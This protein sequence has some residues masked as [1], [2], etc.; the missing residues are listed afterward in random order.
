[1][2]KG[3]ATILFIIFAFQVVY[4]AMFTAW[5]F[6]N[7]AAIAAKY[8]ENKS[9][10]QLHCDGQCFL[11]KKL[12][13]IEEK[14]SSNEMPS[15]QNLWVETQPCI[16]QDTINAVTEFD[17]KPVFHNAFQTLDY[18]FTWISTLLRPPAVHFA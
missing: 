18:Q 15:L 7:R 6:V 3:L 17:W 12:Q 16:P 11:A 14:K 13:A 8:C 4:P 5:F 1:V 2:K 9:R 10:P